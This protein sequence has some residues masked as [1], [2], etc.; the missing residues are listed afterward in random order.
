[1][2]TPQTPHLDLTASPICQRQKRFKLTICIIIACA[3]AGLASSRMT[4]GHTVYAI[5]ASLAATYFFPVA[6]I[7]DIVDHRTRKNVVY[8]L[9]SNYCFGVILA[10]NVVRIFLP[11]DATCQGILYAFYLI[12]IVLMIVH[13]F[14]TDDK[15]RAFLHA[16]FV[17]VIQSTNV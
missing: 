14:I 6:F 17:M 4:G 3:I 10:L 11:N 5:F 2:K 9:M 12:N 8:S 1:M 7:L 15:D 16:I 13:L